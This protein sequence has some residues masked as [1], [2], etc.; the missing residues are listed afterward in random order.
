MYND[1]DFQNRSSFINKSHKDE[2]TGM[3]MT[4]SG[5]GVYDEYQISD[6]DF[7]VPPNHTFNISSTN[8]LSFNDSG[9]WNRNSGYCNNSNSSWNRQSAELLPSGRQ[10]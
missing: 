9:N 7:Q 2:T 10:Q 5:R 6:F 8:P 1:K 4:M 3:T